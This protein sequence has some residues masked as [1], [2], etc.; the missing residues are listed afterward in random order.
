M[1]VWVTLAATALSASV[2]LAFANIDLMQALV[3]AT[4]F[5]AATMFPALLLAIWWKRCT[6]WGA[7]A[8]MVV[9]LLAMSAE[10]LFGD[11][12]G[13]G[14]THLTTV[15]AALIGV[16]IGLLAGIA[17][18]LA[19]PRPS[20]AELAYFEDMRDPRGDALYDRARRR[21][22]AAVAAAAATAATATTPASS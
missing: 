10:M 2:F 7:M 14:H 16:P 9:G 3:T 11:S 15:I 8:A 5:A 19:G 22:A 18:S 20:A 1:M 21:T 13:F 17:A 12:L 6:I 4:A